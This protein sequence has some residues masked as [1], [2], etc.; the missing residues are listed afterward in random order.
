MPSIEIPGVQSIDDIVKAFKSKGP[1]LNR[2]DS[3]IDA[4]VRMK[5][6]P[7]GDAKTESLKLLTVALKKHLEKE[8]LTDN[9]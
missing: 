4:M 1:W 9:G 3:I 8:G 2:F 5:D 6:F 7:E